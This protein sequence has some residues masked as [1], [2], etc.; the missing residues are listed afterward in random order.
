VR[1]NVDGNYVSSIFLFPDNAPQNRVGSYGLLNSR[2]AWASP[3][4]RYEVA[5]WGKNLT[6]TSFITSIAPV[7][8][9][10]QLNY[11]EPRTYGVQVSVRF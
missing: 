8:T 3:D 1:A 9:Q 10:D 4:D 2:L 5:L 6:N 11:N 7:I